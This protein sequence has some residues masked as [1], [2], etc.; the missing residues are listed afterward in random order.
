MGLKSLIQLQEYIYRIII[1]LLNFTVEKNEA[2]L[3][4][5]LPSQN[6]V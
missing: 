6:S 4:A 2:A 1:H 3:S 5:L